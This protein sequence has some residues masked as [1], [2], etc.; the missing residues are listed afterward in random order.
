MMW[1]Y[2]ITMD[3]LST[4][5]YTEGNLNAHICRNTLTYLECSSPACTDV[6]NTCGRAVIKALRAFSIWAPFRSSRVISLWVI[7]RPLQCASHYKCTSLCPCTVECIVWHPDPTTQAGIS[8]ACCEI[9]W[10]IFRCY[11]VFFF[12]WDNFLRPLLRIIF[13]TTLSSH[14]CS[15]ISLTYPNLT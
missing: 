2:V 4:H 11:I 7:C 12:W 8:C 1:L 14:M 15:R 5:V 6:S 9:S 10:G 3:C 13:I